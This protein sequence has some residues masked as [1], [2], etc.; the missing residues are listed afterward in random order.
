M[1]KVAEKF[2]IE[3]SEEEINGYIARMAAQ[4]NQRP[5]RMKEQME[6][7][8]SLAQFKLEVRQDKCVEKLLETAKITEKKPDKKEK[9]PKK[10]TEKTKKKTTKKA[11]KKTESK[12]KES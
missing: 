7:D 9:K 6:H 12:E 11:A 2:G 10:T 1:D 8:G 3:V 5:E 4:R